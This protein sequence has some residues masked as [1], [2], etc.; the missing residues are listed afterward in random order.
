M[1]WTEHF[2][3]F[4]PFK[5]FSA[6]DKSLEPVRNC[7][8]IY[9]ETNQLI[10]STANCLLLKASKAP[11]RPSLRHLHRS[12][13]SWEWQLSFQETL[14]VYT[15]V[16]FIVIVVIENISPTAAFIC[17]FT[18][19]KLWKCI[20]FQVYGVTVLDWLLPQSIIMWPLI[21]HSNF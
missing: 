8:V 17:V 16:L 18:P 20:V 12:E 14:L 15:L 13:L 9:N 1:T 3:S 7:T 5:L 19:V 2:S 6:D 21:V 11:I 10:S 4:Q